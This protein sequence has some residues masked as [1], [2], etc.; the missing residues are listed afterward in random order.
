MNST[1]RRHKLMDYSDRFGGVMYRCLSSH[2]II[3]LR[4]HGKQDTTTGMTSISAIHFRRGD[5][6]ETNRD[7]VRGESEPT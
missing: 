4:E 7:N 5:V 6:T 3:R 2:V 1:G